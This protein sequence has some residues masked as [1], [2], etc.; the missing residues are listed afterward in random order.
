[1]ICPVENAGSAIHPSPACGA[2]MTRRA[3][4]VFFLSGGLIS[5][6][7]RKMP[8]TR[9]TKEKEAMFWRKTDAP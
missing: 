9:K 6:L 7:R 1:M 5:F 8:G 4:L 3:F 2:D